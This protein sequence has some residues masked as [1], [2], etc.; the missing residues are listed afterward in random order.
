MT[1]LDK[2]QT[3][4]LNY[5]SADVLWVERASQRLREINER[6]QINRQGGRK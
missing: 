2:F 3:A 1:P 5:K 6:E 4:L